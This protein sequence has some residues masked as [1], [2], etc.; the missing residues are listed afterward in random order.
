[1]YS[2]F[3]QNIYKFF[4]DI[5]DSFTHN[6]NTKLVNKYDHCE[7]DEKILFLNQT[8]DELVYLEQTI[9]RDNVNLEQRVF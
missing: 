5:Y 6:K 8:D 7:D 9:K 4:L 1:M 2:D 3:F